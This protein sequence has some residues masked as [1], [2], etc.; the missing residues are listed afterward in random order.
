MKIVATRGHLR[1]RAV[2]GRILLK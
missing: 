1:N 2:N